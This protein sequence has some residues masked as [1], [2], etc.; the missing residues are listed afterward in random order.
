MAAELKD[1]EPAD[2]KDRPAGVAYDMWPE[3]LPRI[4]QPR[5]PG[6]QVEVLAFFLPL[7]VVSV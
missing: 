5:S 6:I 1:R 7:K 2:L 3:A 4:R